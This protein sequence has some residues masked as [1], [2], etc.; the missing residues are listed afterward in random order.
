[1]TPAVRVPFLACAILGGVAL[2]AFGAAWAISS[3]LTYPCPFM[4]LFQLPCPTCGATRSLAALARLDLL[5]AIR[6]NPL[7][8]L[9]GGVAL[10]AFLFR[11]KAPWIARRGLALFIGAFLLNWIYLLLW[12]PR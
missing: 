1:M 9:G 12:L 4:Y 5:Q 8:I 2:L 10:A 11:H 3:G 7:V 6:F